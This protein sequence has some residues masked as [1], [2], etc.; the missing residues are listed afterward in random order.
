MRVY[1][2]LS[3]AGMLF[4][5]RYPGEVVGV[6]RPRADRRVLVLNAAL[7]LMVV[8]DVFPLV[9][10][11]QAVVDRRPFSRRNVACPL[12]VARFETASSWD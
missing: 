9:R 10:Q 7:M 5:V 11:L 4:C 12:L 1:G 2:N 6:G 3:L 8:L